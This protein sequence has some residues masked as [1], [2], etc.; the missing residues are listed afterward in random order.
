[1]RMLMWAAWAAFIPTKQVEPTAPLTEIK[2]AYY[3][4]AKECHPVRHH[5][6]L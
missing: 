2:K 4:L 6:V 3:N 1:M 5:S